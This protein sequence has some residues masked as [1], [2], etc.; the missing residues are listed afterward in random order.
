[1]YLTISVLHIS[2]IFQ[3]AFK[4]QHRQWDCDLNFTKK[5]LCLFPIYISSPQ[6]RDCVSKNVAF[7]Q[8]TI[9]LI[10]SVD[11]FTFQPT[12]HQNTGLVVVEPTKSE[13]EASRF[14][15][16]KQKFQF[17]LKILFFSS[18]IGWKFSL[19]FFRQTSGPSTFS[20]LFSAKPAAHSQRR[21]AAITAK[22]EE[23]FKIV[24]GNNHTIWQS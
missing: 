24:D 9:A 17:F 13:V 22:R 4:V 1:M 19:C 15:P 10:F 16:T 14:L 7:H 3:T 11:F 21:G 23:F 20:D 5:S 12:W 2:F 8:W 18:S 6:M